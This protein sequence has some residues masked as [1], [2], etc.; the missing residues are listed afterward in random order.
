M[1][2]I[3]QVKKILSKNI[4]V[5]VSVLDFSKGGEGDDYY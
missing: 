3:E 4:S 2:R 5:T 1:D